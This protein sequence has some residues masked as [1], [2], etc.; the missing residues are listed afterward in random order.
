[1]P[2]PIRI[3][4]IFFDFLANNIHFF[5]WILNWHMKGSNKTFGKNFIILRFF[6]LFNLFKKKLLYFFFKTPVYKKIPLPSDDM[7]LNYFFCSRKTRHTVSCLYFFHKSYF[8][9][10]VQNMTKKTKNKYSDKSHISGALRDTKY[11]FYCSLINFTIGQ[12]GLTCGTLHR[13]FSKMITQPP[14]FSKK[15]RFQHV[16]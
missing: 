15:I 2:P 5:K 1:M 7:T 8:T 10:L 3:V 16:E 4:L 6:G 14:K 9:F 12:L 11:F 13:K